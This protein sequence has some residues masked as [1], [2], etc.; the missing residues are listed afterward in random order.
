MT[1]L[2]KL[3]HKFAAGSIGR[4][5]TLSP[6]R[7]LL[8]FAL[9]CGCAN[10]QE[11]FPEKQVTFYT[12]YGFSVQDGWTIPLKLWVYEEPDYVRNLA[13]RAALGELQDRAE[14]PDLTVEQQG[15]YRFRTH[16]F[17]A[18][19]ESRESVQIRF[20]NDP[21]ATI[22]TIRDAEGESKTDRNG[23]LDGLLALSSSQAE[24]LLEAQ[25][26]DDGWLSFRAVSD[27]HEG[28]G[29]VRLIPAKGVSVISDVDDTIKVTEIPAGE[30]AVLNN[31]FF[32]EFRAAPC[33]ADMY[34]NRVEST[35]YHYVSGGPWQMYR[36]LHEFL[37][38]AA[39]GFPEGSFHMKNVRTNPF[40]SESYRDIWKLIAAGSQAVTFEQKVGQISTLLRQ[41]PDRQF[42]L[43][44][45]SG[46][47]D[48]EVF[49]RIRDD[50]ADQLAEIRIRDVVNAFEMTP[51]RLSGMTVIMPVAD[52]DGTCGNVIAITRP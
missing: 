27:D 36:P 8:L 51:E 2:I 31:T 12:T 9:Q 43:I 26:S 17:V 46:E 45:D 42:I 34:S 10:A 38:S 49:A 44:G 33:M 4:L 16:D 3:L 28:V 1:N 14:L 30:K 32:R 24:S 48:P 39:V 29:R 11:S 52:T 47:K 41:F 37:F 50:F 23:L 7:I 15:R 5:A 18:D 35:A 13:A 19:S 20:D 25:G 6:G 22:F 21:A 40:E